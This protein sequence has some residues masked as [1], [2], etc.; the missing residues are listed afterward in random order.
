MLRLGLAVAATFA[1]A[2]AP[3][4]ADGTGAT[5]GVLRRIFPTQRGLYEDYVANFWC[6]S[7]RLIKWSRLVS[8]GGLVRL[9]GVATL[10]A[11]APAMAS[12]IARPTP[13][14]FLLCL[15]NCAMA[16]FL[17]SYQVGLGRVGWL[18]GGSVVQS[19]ELVSMKAAR[20]PR[21][22]ALQRC[23]IQTMHQRHAGL[24]SPSVSGVWTS[25]TPQAMPAM[26]VHEK[27]ILL[28]LLPLCL[29]LGQEQ[30]RLLR[31]LNTVSVF[32]MVPL[33]KKDSLALAT[34]AATAA[35]HAAI[36]LAGCK[37]EGG[38]EQARQQRSSN[39]SVGQLPDA[40]ARL[41]SRLSLA[42]CATLLAASAAVPPPPRLPFLYDALITSWAFAHFFALFLY[43]NWLQLGEFRQAA[44]VGKAKK[45]M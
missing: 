17:F 4:L 11:A 27:S 38:A 40:I 30:P 20:A 1:I 24:A 8:Q 14:G 6:V 45:R 37:A 13:R 36:T 42:T 12:Q 33:L 32:S 5:L 35:C 16:F 21:L 9:C 41:A 25:V 26:Q 3:W 7:S 15:A 10:A 31:W 19:G 43:T 28:P 22:S 39:S 23:M 34:A 18:A 2:W 29:L 44:P